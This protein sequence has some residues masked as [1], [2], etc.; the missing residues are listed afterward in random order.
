MLYFPCH[1]I[2]LTEFEVRR[3]VRKKP[4]Y[5]NERAGGTSTAVNVRDT[6]NPSMSNFEKASQH[7]LN[8][9]KSYV[10]PP[11]WKVPAMGYVPNATTERACF[12]NSLLPDFFT[13]KFKHCKYAKDFCIQF[14]S[15]GRQIYQIKQ[16]IDNL[17]K[18]IDSVLYTKNP[19]AAGSLLEEDYPV[20][21]SDSIRI[22]QNIERVEKITSQLEHV[23]NDIKEKDG[24]L[25][26]VSGKL[27]SGENCSH[28]EFEK[29]IGQ[30][31]DLRSKAGSIKEKLE[32]LQEKCKR[33]FTST[34]SRPR[35]KERKQKENRRKAKKTKESRMEFNY[36]TVL[37]MIAPQHEWSVED[38][39]H[40]ED[41][42]LEAIAGLSK[43]KKPYI[44]FAFQQNV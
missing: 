33:L 21:P 13:S 12:M 42:N 39:I 10:S 36:K 29:Y 26:T 18:N 15:T 9:L 25:F 8:P 7:S 31:H 2:G 11:Q 1:F 14:H 5:F 43:H 19:A 40:P 34:F 17:G 27:K 16:R 44:A 24:K 35:T 30:V 3:F 22:K 32:Y 6:I 28:K 37:Q 23:L 20:I 41:L 4:E 38:P